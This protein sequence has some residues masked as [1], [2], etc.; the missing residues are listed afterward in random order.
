MSHYQLKK[1]HSVRKWFEKA[2]EA[3]DIQLDDELD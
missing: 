2:A 3:A 1:K